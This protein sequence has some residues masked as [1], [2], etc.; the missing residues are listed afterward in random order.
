[1]EQNE[2]TEG[3]ILIGKFMG[4]Y[5]PK[6]KKDGFPIRNLM[7][8]PDG[9][10]MAFREYGSN[11]NKVCNY[12][13]SLDELYPV[14]EKIKLIVNRNSTI[15]KM[16]TNDESNEMFWLLLFPANKLFEEVVKF[17]HWFENKKHLVH[18]K[19]N[20]NGSSSL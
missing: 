10:R 3:S 6:S 1:M 20:Y 9:Q 8:F 17:L 13:N 12:Y 4:G 15:Q 2:I 16:W 19:H 18:Q 11:G 5:H 14:V 7:D